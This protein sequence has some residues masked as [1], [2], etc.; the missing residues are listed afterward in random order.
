MHNNELKSKMERQIGISLQ[1]LEWFIL[2]GFMKSVVE[3]PEKVK[4]LFKTVEDSQSIEL[5]LSKIQRQFAPQLNKVAE[6]SELEVMLDIPSNE[7]L[8]NPPKLIVDAGL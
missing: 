2:Y 4:L 8:T 7:L 3:D 5:I 6:K 1:S